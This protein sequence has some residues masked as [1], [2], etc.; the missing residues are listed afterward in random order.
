M[1]APFLYIY[2]FTVMSATFTN[3]F[4]DKKILERK[5]LNRL[6]LRNK[7]PPQS[8]NT[9]LHKRPSNFQ[10]SSQLRDVNAPIDYRL[11]IVQLFTG[12]INHFYVN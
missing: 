12:V 8:S 1:Q 2:C 3:H 4:P 10:S 6:V 9:T 5:M 7:S 11:C